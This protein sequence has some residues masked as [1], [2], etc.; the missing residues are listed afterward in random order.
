M[1]AWSTTTVQATLNLKEIRRIP[2]PWPPISERTGIA[3]TVR[4]FDERID[5]IN[6]ENRSLE[7]IVRTIFKSWFLDFDPVRA[8]DEGIEAE[9]MDSDTA[10][11]F[12]CDFAQQGDSPIPIGWT[13]GALRDVCEAVRVGVQKAEMRPNE[14]YV[15]LEHI[16][17]ESWSLASWGTAD[18][19]QSG[20]SRFQQGEILFGKLRPYFHKVCIAPVD[21]VCSTDVLVL[22]PKQP[23]W[24]AFVL[25]H[26]SSKPLIDYAT[27][28]SNGAKMP[29]TSWHDLS[30]YK[31]VLPPRS[32][33]ESFNR[34][35]EPIL[36]KI[37]ANIHAAATLTD[38]RDTLLPRLILGKLRVREA[39][40]LV[41]AV[42]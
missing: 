28:L 13:E 19:L 2:L 23:C 24:M 18:A 33:A 3:E 26:M 5:V 37:N 8:K 9:G 17:R 4:V 41:E 42:V 27:R 39:Q 21:G 14:N 12:P 35:V 10:A 34:I 40:K 38:L 31:I 30:V 36:E 7:A 1:R 25:C 32:L 22:K 16:P 15:G 29:R 11:L 6:V 20:K